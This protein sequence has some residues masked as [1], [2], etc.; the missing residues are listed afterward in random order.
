MDFWRLNSVFWATLAADYGDRVQAWSHAKTGILGD[1]KHAHMS[2]KAKS[3]K[4]DN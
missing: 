4:T 1:G 2:F 3:Q